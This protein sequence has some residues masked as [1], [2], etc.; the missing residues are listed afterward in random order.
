MKNK[1]GF[2]SA[3]ALCAVGASINANAGPINGTLNF[4]G[5]AAE[6]N[7]TLDVA[8]SV[9]TFGPVTFAGSGTDDYSPVTL[10]PVAITPFAFGG[11][12]LTPN[13]VSLWSFSWLGLTYSFDMYSPLLVERETDGA[14]N[15]TLSISGLGKANIT[16]FDETAGSWV[17]TTQ[18]LAGAP[19]TSKLSFS[20]TQQSPPSFT[21]PDGGSTVTLMGCSLLAVGLVRRKR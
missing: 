13:P 3:I 6:F 18:S 12:V 4:I 9:T 16:G 21:I 15:M 20:A 5:I 17:F 19:A 7:G 14:G 1:L 11:G 8:T 10:V 2:V